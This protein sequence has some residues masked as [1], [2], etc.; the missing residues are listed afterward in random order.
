MI[1]HRFP[2]VCV[3]SS[4]DCCRRH[5]I[6]HRAIDLFPLKKGGDDARMRDLAW[7]TN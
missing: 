6:S 4:C 7:E 3:L 2:H 1:F 5:L